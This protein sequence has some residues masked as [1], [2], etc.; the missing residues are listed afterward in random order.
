MEVLQNFTASLAPSGSDGLDVPPWQ[1]AATKAIV[2][3]VAAA[4]G[5]RVCFLLPQ[6]ARVGGCSPREVAEAWADAQCRFHRS[7]RAASVLAPNAG[8]RIESLNLSVAS[9]V[10][11][12][13][14][15]E[16]QPALV[17]LA[18]GREHI[19]AGIKRAHSKA[20]SLLS[21]L[22]TAAWSK[23]LPRS[24]ARGCRGRLPP[25][26]PLLLPLLQV[27]AFVPGF[28]N[29]AHWPVLQSNVEWLRRQE[30]VEATCIVYVYKP[31]A[32]F[33]VDA[34]LLSP[35]E[36]VR[37]RGLWPEF[38]LAAPEASWKG[39][40][41]VLMMLDNVVMQPSTSLRRMAEIMACN[42]L[43]V[44][45][46]SYHEICC[47]CKSDGCV[48]RRFR[49]WYQSWQGVAEVGRRVSLIDWQVVLMTT[50]A[51]R[52]YRGITEPRVDIA[53]WEPTGLFLY[54]CADHCMAILD[55]ALMYDT[56]V[57]S[58]SYDLA[59]RGMLSYRSRHLV[60]RVRENSFGRLL[61][62]R[63]HCGGV[64]PAPVHEYPAL[65]HPSQLLPDE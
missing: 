64:A 30:G 12:T 31:E 41:Y 8:L 11:T 54:A 47:A 52:C 15:D 17:A 1:L 22:K 40:D 57:A 20:V 2:R 35:C 5:T 56:A 24:C 51:F 39:S 42:R 32:D 29:M 13:L 14:A 44:L 65:L 45:S 21:L 55:E 16:L 36:V 4:L 61:D 58:Y 3:V 59:V 63:R 37:K 33:P 26:P 49:S 23:R 50:E 9:V 27:F 19:D 25:R 48:P 53:N 10:R 34:G 38:V 43:G 46:P 6:R 28:G 18:E 62:P 60:P 7:L